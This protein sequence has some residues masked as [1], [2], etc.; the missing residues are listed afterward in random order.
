MGFPPSRGLFT[1]QKPILS[2]VS[3]NPRVYR[4]F[5]R[6]GGLHILSGFVAH[7]SHFTQVSKSQSL[8]S[9]KFP[10]IFRR[11]LRRFLRR[12]SRNFQFTINLQEFFQFPIT[13]YLLHHLFWVSSLQSLKMNGRF[14]II[15]AF[16]AFS[17]TCRPF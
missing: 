2:L 13:L 4:Q 14:I 9:L 5:N 8:N 11:I 10:L 12:H 3:D 17:V 15:S 1:S 7:F 6:L 16:L